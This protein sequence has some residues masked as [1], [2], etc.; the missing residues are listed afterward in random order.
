MLV[1]LSKMEQ[2]YQAVLEVQVDGLRVSEV[3]DKFGVSRQTVHD[4]LRRYEAGGL[5]ALGDRSHRPSSCPHQMDAGVEAR[6]CELRREHPF[7]GR[8]L[9]LRSA[10]GRRPMNLPRSPLASR[11]PSMPGRTPMA[12]QQLFERGTQVQVRNHFDE[13]WA[14]GFEIAEAK[15]KTGEDVYR[16][17]RVSDRV[18]LPADFFPTDIRPDGSS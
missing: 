15:L 11:R 12:E 6:V 7:W 2:R 4:W 18:V 13:S 3:A 1:E 5:N 9:R 17:R 16:L 8:P 10:G 14:S